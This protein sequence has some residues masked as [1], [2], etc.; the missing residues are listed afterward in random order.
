MAWEKG[1]VAARRDTEHDRV[2]FGGTLAALAEAIHA[3]TFPT[4]LLIPATV[5]QLIESLKIDYENGGFFDIGTFA[6]GICLANGT[7]YKPWSDEALQWI[8]DNMD[9]FQLNEFVGPNDSLVNLCRDCAERITWHLWIHTDTT[10]AVPP[11]FDLYPDPP[12]PP[13][14]RFSGLELDD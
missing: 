5:D 4:V 14:N 13:L 11:P 7:T 10:R 12:R 1:C 8:E 9:E 3:L 2:T 6:C